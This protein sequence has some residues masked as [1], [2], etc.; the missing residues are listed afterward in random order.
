[1]SNDATGL[2][3]KLIYFRGD[4]R[5]LKQPRQLRVSNEWY[6]SAGELVRAM[7]LLKS[8]G[9]WTQHTA[10]LRQAVAEAEKQAIERRSLPMLSRDGRLCGRTGMIRPQHLC[11]SRAYAISGCRLISASEGSSGACPLDRAGIKAEQVFQDL[12]R[13]GGGRCFLCDPAGDLEQL[14]E[15]F[16]EIG[17][18]VRLRGRGD[19]PGEQLLLAHLQSVKFEM[20]VGE[21]VPSARCASQS[22]ESEE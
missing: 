18:L 12:A 10:L 14:H 4:D 21:R 6:T 9:G 11:I 15:R 13:A 8:W 2:R 3:V 1:M 19:A 5:N 16:R 7:L 17:E 22:Q 20:V